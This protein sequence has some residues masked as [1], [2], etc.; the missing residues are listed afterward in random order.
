MPKTPEHF[1]LKFASAGKAASMPLAGLEACKAETELIGQ[2]F[3]SG[4]AGQ[5]AVAD[6]LPGDFRRDDL[7]RLHQAQGLGERRP[8]SL[9]DEGL[10]Q[11]FRQVGQEHQSRPHGLADRIGKQACG[12]GPDRFERGEAVAFG[13][14]YDVVGLGHRQL[15]LKAAGL[16]RDE[17][18]GTDGRAGHV[19]RLEEDQIELSG[20]VF[21]ADD[22]GL[23]GATGLAQGEDPHMRCQDFAGGEIVSFRDCAQNTP[24]NDPFGQGEQQVQHASAARDFLQQAGVPGA[25]AGQARQR[26]EKRC[27]TVIPA[28]FRKLFRFGRVRERLRELFGRHRDNGRFPCS[29]G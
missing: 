26:C 13:P 4:E 23:S 11:P 8:F 24:V 28:C 6:R 16:A 7:G 14:A 5:G 20:V 1:G 22:G 15:T 19:A 25:D 10:V 3:I 18:F 12:Q 17:E 29:S 21:G 27:E 9:G 2:K